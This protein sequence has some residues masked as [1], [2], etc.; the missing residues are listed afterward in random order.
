MSGSCQ[1][2]KASHIIILVD[3]EKAFD[4]IKYS[5]MIKTQSKL[6]TEWKFLNLRNGIYKTPTIYIILNGEKLHA[7]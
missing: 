2:C 4:K 3:A 7:F 1:E 6:G 5:F